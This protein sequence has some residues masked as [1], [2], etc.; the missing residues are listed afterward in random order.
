MEQLLEPSGERLSLG[1]RAGDSPHARRPERKSTRPFVSTTT[2]NQS[3]C[4]RLFYYLFIFFWILP[5][6]C[7]SSVNSKQKKKK[8]KKKKNNSMDA[9]Y[10]W[11]SYKD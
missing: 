6:Y 11:K 7:F 2:V 9:E 3:R 8:K 4:P 10:V 5:F 1:R